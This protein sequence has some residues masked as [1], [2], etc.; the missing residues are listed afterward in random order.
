MPMIPAYRAQ[1]WLVFNQTI[2]QKTPN[3]QSHLAK[4]S[5]VQTLFLIRSISLAGLGFGFYMRAGWAGGGTARLAV[6]DRP[7]I[8]S[9]AAD[10]G[11]FRV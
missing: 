3:K 10:R 7:E 9:N 2:E 1:F 6:A 11:C 4:T 8:I 5:F